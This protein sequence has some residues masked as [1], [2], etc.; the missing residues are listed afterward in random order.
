MLHNLN[1]MVDLETTGTRAGCCILSIGLVM[2]DRDAILESLEI[3]VDH[4]SCIE[5]DMYDDPLTLQWWDEQA[6]EARDRAFSGRVHIN[7][8][9]GRVREFCGGTRKGMQVWGNGSDFDLPI[10]GHAFAATN[11]EWVTDFWNH[12]CYRTV[13]NLFRSVKPDPLE[14]VK[15]GAVDDALFQARH[16]LKIHKRITG[17]A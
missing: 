6:V 17:V 14:G 16:L 5:Y 15:H 4:G 7:D 13:K 3:G 8:A 10:L 9:I 1:L 2:F 11:Q 12:R